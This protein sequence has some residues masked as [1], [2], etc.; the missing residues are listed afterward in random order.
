MW[1]A[2][3]SM[4]DSTH[5]VAVLAGMLVAA[6]VAWGTGKQQLA[7]HERRITKV[8]VEKREDIK[9]LREE[10]RESFK[11]LKQEIAKAKR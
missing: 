11:E 3:K 2:L 9:E 7:D 1:K 6:G 4:L 8:E 10:M 5:L